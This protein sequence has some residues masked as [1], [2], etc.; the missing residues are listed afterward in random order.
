MNNPNIQEGRTELSFQVEGRKYLA[1]LSMKK[2]TGEKTGEVQVETIGLWEGDWEQG[3]VI[4]KF[5]KGTMKP[6]F[7]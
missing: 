3:V 6:E 5:R 1:Y 4:Q 2:T 7:R